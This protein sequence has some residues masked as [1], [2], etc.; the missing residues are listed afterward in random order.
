MVSRRPAGSGAASIGSR[1]AHHPGQAQAL[2]AGRHDREVRRPAQHLGQERRGVDNV[3]D[4]VDDQQHRATPEQLVQHRHGPGAVSAQA[5]GLGD[6]LGHRLGIGDRG[7]RHEARAVVVPVG[8]A[9]RQLDRQ[10]GLAHPSGP[11]EREQPGAR[12]EVGQDRELVAATDEWRRRHRQR[13]A[14]GGREGG[15]SG[16]RRGVVLQL[17]RCHELVAAA[18]DRADHAL[19]PPVVADGA[20][21][22]LE[23]AGER[24]LADEAVAPD[25]VEQLLLGDHAVTVLDEVGEEIEHPGLDANPLSGPTEGKDLRVQG[26]LAEPIAHRW[27]LRS[28][29]ATASLSPGLALQASQPLLRLFDLRPQLGVAVLPQLEEAAVVPGGFLEGRDCRL[30]LAP[31]GQRI[32][33]LA[34]QAVGAVVE[35]GRARGFA[36]VV[37]RDGVVCELGVVADHRPLHAERVHLLEHLVELAAREARLPALELV[38]PHPDHP[39]GLLG[40]ARALKAY[41]PTLEEALRDAGHLTRDA[42]KGERKKYGQRGARARFQYSKR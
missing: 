40:V 41:D 3:L 16:G 19:R 21:R 5:E 9:S 35:P 12:R 15:R 30:G 22:G 11:G 28:I 8:D 24:R 4:V 13:C 39:L 1:A 32:A 7:E 33:A 36:D 38:L 14:P 18:V 17:D 6:L 10:P 2:T 29:L 34:R 27:T 20:A 23:P 26:V 37:G 25:V 42:R 31:L